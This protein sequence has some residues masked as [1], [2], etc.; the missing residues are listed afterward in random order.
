[1]RLDSARRDT[2]PI[3]RILFALTY[4]SAAGHGPRRYTVSREMEN[5]YDRE[6]RSELCDTRTCIGT[7]SL[8]GASLE[9]K[10]TSSHGKKYHV[11][12]ASPRWLYNLALF[13]AGK[14]LTGVNGALLPVSRIDEIRLRGSSLGTTLSPG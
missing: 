14:M 11:R 3:V 8:Y 4:G 9:S 1:M 13:A 5:K 2:G 6:R 7:E 10:R 12:S